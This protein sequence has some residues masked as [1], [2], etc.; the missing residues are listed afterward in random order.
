M[1]PLQEIKAQIEQV[2]KLVEAGNK[3]DIKLNAN[4]GNSILLVCPPDQEHL[5]I[6]ESRKTLSGDKYEMIDLN[7]LLIDFIGQH[8]EEVLEKFDLLQSSVHQIFKSPP[9][10]N[11]DDFFKY[12]IERINDAFKAGKIPFLYSVGA[13]YGTGIDNIHIIE[14]EKIMKAQLPLVILYPATDT[15][16]KLM[17]LNTR[18]ASKYRCMIIK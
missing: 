1:K 15:K 14:H 2:K 10:E 3:S 4:G 18:V 5:F 7:R 13:L 11:D 12:I 16:D 6:D 9:E 17:F 8:K